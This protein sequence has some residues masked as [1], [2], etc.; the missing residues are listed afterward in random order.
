MKLRPDL[1]RLPVA[2]ES[3]RA[4]RLRA[5]LPRIALTAAIALLALGGLRGAI[6]GRP[7]P[8]AATVRAAAPIADPAVS[9]FAEAFARAYL[10]WGDE[11]KRARSLAP[12]LPSWLDSDAGLR[13]GDRDVQRVAWTAVTGSEAHEARTLVVVAAQTSAGMLQLSVPVER[14][15]RGFLYVSGYPA[16]VGPPASDDDA[17]APA[18]QPVD[19]V[20]LSTVVSR[21]LTN[22]LARASDNLRADLTPDAV[23]SLPGEALHTSGDARVTW[24]V[25]GRRVAAEVDAVD[26]RG[27]AWTLRYE[28]DVRRLG[29]WYV[30]SLHVN[31][32]FQGGS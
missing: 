8:A 14:D 17:S 20:A 21:A 31:P 15:K 22:Y 13:P 26:R 19:D 2:T 32:T 30:R 4:L 7:A 23:V 29:R 5:R 6:A 9:A 3:M 27:T 12:F 25:P 18:E 24:I 16:I 28:L 10:R 11:D 1:P